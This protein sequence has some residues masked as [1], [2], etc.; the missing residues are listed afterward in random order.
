MKKEFK[1][2]DKVKW[3]HSSNYPDITRGKI[4]TI[5]EVNSYQHSV[6]VKDNV[7]LSA[8][9]YWYVWGHVAPP[10]FGAWYKSTVKP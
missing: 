4:Y 9:L 6:T 5:T 8:D 1:V 2:G 7:G 3:T 10:S